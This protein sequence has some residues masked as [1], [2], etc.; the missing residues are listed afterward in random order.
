[1]FFSNNGPN[2]RI[3]RASMDGSDRVVIV[4][5]GL[6][7]VRDLSVDTARN[8]LFWAEHNG[9]DV[10]VCNYDGSN[11]RVFP[12]LITDGM[13]YYQVLYKALLCNDQDMHASYLHP[14]LFLYLVFI[15]ILK[16]VSLQNKER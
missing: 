14:C 12:N 16:I 13:H 3:E 10:E 7:R 1:M 4:H 8:I 9:Y 5:T 6:M 11:R 15:L 2:P